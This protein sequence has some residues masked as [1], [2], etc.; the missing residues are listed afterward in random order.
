MIVLFKNVIS[1]RRYL[2]SSF[3]GFCDRGVIA[4]LK[5]FLRHSRLC[6]EFVPKRYVVVVDYWPYISKIHVISSGLKMHLLQL[7]FS[8]TFNISSDVSYQYLSGFI[9][10]GVDFFFKVFF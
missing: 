8:L 2:R 1:V 10:L 5:C 6:G 9:N 3:S 7:L 4:I